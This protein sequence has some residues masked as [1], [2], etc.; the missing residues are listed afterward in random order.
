MNLSRFTLAFLLLFGSAARL[1]AADTPGFTP[2]PGYKVDVEMEVSEDGTVEAAKV[3]NSD[4]MSGDAVLQRAAL[5]V[6]GR[7]KLPVREKDGKPVKYK[8]QAPIYFPVADDEGP[9]SNKA[10]KPRIH[11]APQILY[12]AGLAEQG[13]VGGAIVEIIVGIDGNV[14][15]IKVL[16]SSHPA[17]AQA[18]EE[19]V[20]KWSFVPAMKDG[21]PVESRWRM[22]IT[23]STDAL[24]ADWNWR[25]APR[26]S[27]GN[28]TVARRVTP[29]PPSAGPL[30]PTNLSIQPSPAPA[31]A[32]EKK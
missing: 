13:I 17:F 21:Q 10:P 20:K 25:V 5:G 3:I 32:P 30:A 22:A 1:A 19:G 6:A 4:D 15:S 8:A 26:P 29:N 24:D 23:F 14:S 28:Y 11:A 18:A 27:L 12:P 31:S 2:K 9:E 16:R 7:M